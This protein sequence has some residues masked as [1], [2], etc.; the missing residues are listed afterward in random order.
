MKP[1]LPVILNAVFF[2]LVIACCPDMEQETFIFNVES[3]EPLNFNHSSIEFI[4]K[5]SSDVSALSYAMVF[6]TT[7][8]SILNAKPKSQG[9]GI[10]K[11]PDCGGSIDPLFL[12]EDQ[13]V[14]LTITATEDFSQS[15]PAGVDLSVL[16][17]AVLITKDNPFSAPPSMI[18]HISGG[19]KIQDLNKEV[20]RYHEV[21]DYRKQINVSFYGFKLLEQPSK[22]ILLQFKLTF[23]FQSGRTISGFTEPILLR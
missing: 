21:V 8:P 9:G 18:E 16:F 19:V 20:I 3:V 15:Y 11:S 13:I 17:S 4:E 2:F 10:F 23:T 1:R 6:Q 22:P 7:A 5:N 12:M 14:A